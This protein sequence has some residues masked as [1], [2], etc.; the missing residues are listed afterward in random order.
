MGPTLRGG[1]RDRVTIPFESIEARLL[2]DTQKSAL[3][4]AGGEVDEME[5]RKAN[6]MSYNGW[7]KADEGGDMAYQLFADQAA[8]AALCRRHHIRRLSLFGSRLKGTARADS[9]VDLLVEFEPGGTPGLIRLGGIARELSDLL[10][11]RKVDLRTDGDLSRYFR[12]EVVRTAEVQFA[13]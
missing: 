6:A 12:D 2:R 4:R 13:A 9:D 11:G 3:S 10:G 1:E 7:L 5:A 8:L